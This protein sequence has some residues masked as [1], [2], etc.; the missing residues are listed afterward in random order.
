MFNNSTILNNKLSSSFTRGVVFFYVNRCHPGRGIKQKLQN[1]ATFLTLCTAFHRKNCTHIVRM[2]IRMYLKWHESQRDSILTARMFPIE[3]WH[4]KSVG[5]TR[6]SKTKSRAA[7]FTDFLF[8]CGLFAPSR[9]R[10]GKEGTGRGCVRGGH[11]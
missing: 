11:R 1:S 9:K 6:R 4:S 8:L 5:R 3:R 10:G 2:Y 7:P